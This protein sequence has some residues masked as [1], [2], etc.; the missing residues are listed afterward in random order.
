MLSHFLIQ[1]Q[2]PQEKHKALKTPINSLHFY[3]LPENTQLK[4]TTSLEIYTYRSLIFRKR[5]KMRTNVSFQQALTVESS[6]IVKQALSL[7]KRR[8]H[9]HVTPLH[10]ASAMLVSSSSTLLRKACFQ[11]NSHPIQYKALELCFNVA[12][13]R[14]P[15][16]ASNPILEPHVH[17][18]FLS[19]ALVAAFKRAQA[20]Q[21]RGSV[22]NQQQQQHLKVEIDQ[23]VISILD[24]PSVSRV[25]SEAGFSSI[26][27]KTNVEHAI[28]SENSTK[29]MVIASGNNLKLSLCKSGDDPSVSRVMREA[30][31]S[32]IQLKTN[33]EHA[34]SSE[35]SWKNSSK[36][37]VI[38]PGDNLKLSL[39]KSSD[40]QIKNDDVMSVIEAMMNKKRRNTVI[41]AEC[42]ANAEGV[43][44]G[45]VDKFDKGEV[46]SHM[47][48]VQFISVPLSTLRNV[49]KEEFEAKIRELRIL[50]KSC[51][52][53]GVVLYLGDLEWI[54]E[55]WTKVHN[56]QK[57]NYMILELSRLLCG[58]MSEN[59]R[60]W[61]MG[62]ASFPTYTKCKTGCPSLRTL[63]DLHP[64]TLP[65]VSLDLNLNL[66]SSVHKH[67]HNFID[68]GLFSPS[69][70]SPCSS[71]SISSSS[72]K[73]HQ[74]LNTKP[75]LL[76]NPNSIPNSASSSEASGHIEHLELCCSDSPEM[77]LHSCQ[78]LQKCT[79]S[80]TF[81]NSSSNVKILC[82]ALEKVVP[83]QKDIIHDI[84]STILERR[85]KKEET[86][87]LFLGVDSHGKE[88]ISK[89]LAKIIFGSQDCFIS[90]GLSTFSSSTRTDSTDQEVNNK[91][92]R[93]EQGRSYLERFTNAIQENPRRVFFMED[94]D[95]VDSFSQK[96]IQKAI[97]SGKL[98]LPNGDLVLIK[99]SII[100]FSCEEYF[101]SISRTCFPTNIQKFS[102]ENNASLDLNIAIGENRD[103]KQIMLKI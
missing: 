25:M 82:K 10:V 91:R 62:I 12:L 79:H 103:E 94:M 59:G 88:K 39:G 87:L 13:N 84:V 19:N 8:G 4:N 93:D 77:L 31:F 92:S 102:E 21:R 53:R 35:I 68:K 69:S 26:Q 54:S 29:P 83:W 75:E 55:F 38:P 11:T 51:I 14:L 7:A 73:E 74:F 80:S 32:S 41:V 9:S 56:E 70:S 43:V 65:V 28:S 49:S 30:G 99:D 47:K 58:E 76:S 98:T 6:S 48:H 45:V 86:W 67:D 42:L 63:W 18:P 2:Q 95:Q 1:N 33:V 24:D 17:P 22:E 72:K 15:T 89:E 61:L 81:L 96:G 101:S 85:H 5:V 78:I 44:R 50:L 57:N 36:L 97:E 46:S 40:D 66:E 16:S 20:Y 60:L 71:T 100:I 27:L 34:I 90:I 52:H 37:M 64:L 3:H 23:L